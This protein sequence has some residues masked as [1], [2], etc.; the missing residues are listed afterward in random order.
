MYHISTQEY[1][2]FDTFLVY[3]AFEALEQLVSDKLQIR[4]DHNVICP[5][6]LHMNFAPFQ[7]NVHVNP[8]EEIRNVID[9]CFSVMDKKLDLSEFS[10]HP[11]FA[12]IELALHHP[13]TMSHVLITAARRHF[14]D[15]QTICLAGNG[16]ETTL[17]TRPLTWMTKLTKLDFS[18]N[19]VI[20]WTCFF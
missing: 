15:V 17:G 2:K 20:S 6:Q 13:A 1:P 9:Q 3:N 7:K 5:V 14:G 12:H 10:N 19:K 8:L 11:E 18:N 16:L 4:M